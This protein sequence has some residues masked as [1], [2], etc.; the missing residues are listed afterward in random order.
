MQWQSDLD[1]DQAAYVSEMDSPSLPGRKNSRQTRRSSIM[2]RAFSF[3]GPT[4][5]DA[6]HRRESGEDSA[7]R[8]SIIERAFSFVAPAGEPRRSRESGSG[9]FT[10]FGSKG[11]R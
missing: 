1:D 4:G 7:R 5:Q 10:L 2:E 3:I 9:M 11:S 6:R 8:S